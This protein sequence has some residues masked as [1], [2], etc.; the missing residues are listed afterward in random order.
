MAVPYGQ[1]PCISG[2]RVFG[3][4]S[5][6]APAVPCYSAE[7]TNDLDMNVEIRPQD[8]AL[9]Y[10]ILFGSG[11]E[12]LYHSMMVYAPGKHRVGALIAGRDYVVR[13]DAFNEN[14]ITEGVC[15]KVK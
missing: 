8:D 4:G 1:R 11:E 15:V 6:K 2:L 14:G 7:R 10:N 13:V 3:L 9:G 12:K 5:G